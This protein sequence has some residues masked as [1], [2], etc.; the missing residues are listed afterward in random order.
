MTTFGNAPLGLDMYHLGIVVPDMDEALE[1]YSASFGFH[2]TEVSQSTQ[3]VLVAGN[4]QKTTIKACYSVEGPPYLEL[5]EDVSGD[6]WGDAAYGMNHT[7][8]WAEDIASV[9][10][11]LELSG[12]S[13]LVVDA[14][15]DPPRFTYHKAANGMWIELVSPGFRP[16]LL[17]RVRVAQERIDTQSMGQ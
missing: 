9:R 8:F 6:V 11:R 7:G 17:E 2:W 5:I 15:E 16:R 13:A 12:L 3:D 1:T 10:D 4:R 14:S